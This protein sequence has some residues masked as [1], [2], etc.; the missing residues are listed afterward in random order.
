MAGGI[1]AARRRRDEEQKT[2]L[3]ETQSSSTTTTST[4][5]KTTAASLQDEGGPPMDPIKRYFQAIIILAVSLYGL[6][7]S[8][9]VENLLWSKKINR[10][11]VA[12][13]VMASSLVVCLWCYLDY[14][15]GMIQG[16]KVNYTEARRITHVILLS[17]FVTGVALN[18]ALWPVYHLASL[19]LVA[20]L[21]YGVLFQFLIIFPS[22]VY[23]PVFFAM[24]A[25][26]V[27]LWT[28]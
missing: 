9:C 16:Q 11:A 15:V 26:F 12:V 20:M 17:I 22:Y 4:T 23:N 1:E 27:Y 14:F 7:E 10:P 3:M 13:A 24:Y 8:K 19:V 28:R 5:T 21:S 18:V 2:Q 6:L 25:G